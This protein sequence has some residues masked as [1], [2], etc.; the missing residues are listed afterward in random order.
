MCYC[1]GMTR[2][3]VEF[4]F[5]QVATW[6]DEAQA[7]FVASFRQISAKHVRQLTEEE[8]AAVRRGLAEMRARQ[9]ASREEVT[10]LFDRFR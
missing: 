5:E 1:L 6:S 3:D 8:V 4:M 2:D 7:E 10:A 9:L